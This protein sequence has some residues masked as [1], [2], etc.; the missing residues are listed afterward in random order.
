MEPYKN[1]IPLPDEHMRMVG[2]I[3]AL[4]EHIERMLEIALAEIMGLE[5]LRISVLTTNLGFQ[6]KC[7][8]ILLHARLFKDSED[9]EIR[10]YWKHFSRVYEDLKKAQELR[11]KYV[12]AIWTVDPENPEHLPTRNSLRTTGKKL[13]IIEDPTPVSELYQAAD[14]IWESGQEFLELLRRFGLLKSSP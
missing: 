12:H 9:P 10:G 5:E 13:Q 2:I 3:A 1:P 11:S 14:A 4:W 6:T 7:D 8:I